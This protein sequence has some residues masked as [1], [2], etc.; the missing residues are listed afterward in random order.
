MYIII[1]L[2]LISVLIIVHELGHFLSARAFGM[3]VEKFGFGLPFGPTLWKGKWGDTEIIVHA[4]L[5]GGYISFPDDEKDC[6]LPKDSPLRFQNKPLYQRAVVVSAGVVAN[7]LCAIF[8]V[9]LSASI[10]HKLPAFEYDV[11]A[12][13]ILDINSSVKTSGMKEG[14]R[15]Y[16]INSQ[17]IT[18]PYSINQFAINSR[19]FDG[20][21][22][23]TIVLRKI[24]EL[25]K[26]N[27][28]L[29]ENDLIKQN[30]IIKLPKATPEKPLSLTQYQLMGVEKYENKELELSDEQ[31]IL[32]NKIYQ[33]SNYKS[34]GNITLKDIAIASS[35]TYKP[36][37]IT[38]LRNN[39]IIKLNP[40]ESNEKGL[41]GIEQKFNEVF[42]PTKTLQSIIGQSFNYLW[43]N[44]SMI[45]VGLEKIFTGKV[46]YENMR[47]IIAVTK[48][49]GDIIQHQGMFKGF[50][51]TAIISLNLAIVNF[52][53]IPALDGGH[54]L[55]MIIEKI[56]GKA[57]DE[58]VIENIG[59]AGFIFLLILMFLLLFN[60][61]Y[62][63]ITKAI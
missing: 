19:K 31:K 35:D 9:I 26:L 2:L 25:K 13:K 47:S 51:L 41:V 38:V 58:K 33:K 3:K 5:L 37:Y 15:I 45:F 56:R 17:K 49:G 8:L 27:P 34:E 61:I 46:E 60:D 16:E 21:V 59:N 42:V 4:L 50:L 48:I 28:N 54:I 43:K 7:I 62:A 30:I 40:I 14:D 6:E 44:T 10:W 32:R 11:Y 55:F 18:L 20:K 1:M 52:L 57:L 24:K 39:K 23:E 53:P 29:K 12:N 22:D 36:L 63:L